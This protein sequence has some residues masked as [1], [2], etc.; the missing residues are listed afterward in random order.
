MEGFGPGFYHAFFGFVDPS[1]DRSGPRT[2]PALPRPERDAHRHEHLQPL[3]TPAEQPD[4]RARTAGGRG[5]GRPER[6]GPAQRD[7]RGLYAAPCNR[8]RLLHD[9][10]RAAGH[11]PAGDLGQAARRPVRLQHDHRDRTSPSG[12]QRSGQRPFLPL[13]RHLRRQRVLRRESE[14]LPR[15]G[16]GRA[17]PQQAVNLRFRDGTI[18]MAD[19]DRRHGRLRD[20]RGVS[21]LQVAGGG[22]GLRPL[23]GH[24]HDGGRGRGRTSSRRT[25]AGPCPRTAC[26][27][28][29][30]SMR[31]TP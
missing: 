13:V 27:I 24:R 2:P 19:R 31:R 16:R 17:F 14:R 10:Q 8:G 25:T 5:L 12:V 4:V 15:P 21:L 1:A 6:D 7:R 3:R 23:Q 30:R 20:D 9:H 22:G 26:A 11:L 18:Y 29:S 28:R